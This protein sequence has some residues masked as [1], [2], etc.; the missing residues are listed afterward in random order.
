MK[1]TQEQLKA[2]FCIE[3]FGQA[4]MNEVL[5]IMKNHGLDKID[6]CNISLHITPELDL[7]CRSI[8]IGKA[9]TDFGYCTL[10]RGTNMKCCSQARNWLKS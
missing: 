3:Q 6:G 10:T 1:L 7:T 8:S 4:Y 2:V 9:G 5:H